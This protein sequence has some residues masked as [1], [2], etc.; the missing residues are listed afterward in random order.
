MA[1]KS[2]P[3][4][5]KVQVREIVDRFNRKQLSRSG[6]RYIPRFKSSGG[7][8]YAQ[9]GPENGSSNPTPGVP[10]ARPLSVAM[11]AMR[12]YFTI[13]SCCTKTSRCSV[14]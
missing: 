13:R 11:S 6:R 5:V 4:D 2:I 12:S 10:K 7:P 8:R 1:A 3:D 14:S 9:T